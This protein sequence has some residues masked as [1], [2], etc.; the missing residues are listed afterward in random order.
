MIC[1]QKKTRWTWGLF[2][3]ITYEVFGDIE[4]VAPEYAGENTLRDSDR[5]L[6]SGKIPLAEEPLESEKTPPSTEIA[7]QPE[8]TVQESDLTHKILEAKEAKRESPSMDGNNLPPLG[9]EKTSLEVEEAIQKNAPEGRKDGQKGGQE[10]EQEKPL[11]DQ[12]GEMQKGPEEDPKELFPGEEMDPI[13]RN[14][15]REP[16]VPVV[17]IP[18]YKGALTKEAI[19]HENLKNPTLGC[20]DVLMGS[21][22]YHD[23]TVNLAF[24]YVYTL[25]LMEMSIQ[26]YL[27]SAQYMQ[28]EAKGLLDPGRE[29]LRDLQKI[30]PAYLLGFKI[31]KDGFRDG[32]LRQILDKAR[33]AFQEKQSGIGL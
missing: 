7:L 21:Q 4:K 1:K 11:Q 24:T 26:K 6:E 32:H 12:R 9:G 17:R 20:T 25:C 27:Q 30:L 5:L 22:I 13:L 29:A 18:T 2:F 31:L 3:L 28:Y 14:L 16:V 15:E 10:G 19:S 23:P 8:E 33:K